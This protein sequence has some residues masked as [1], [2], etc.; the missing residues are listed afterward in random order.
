MSPIPVGSQFAE[1]A[2]R[3]LPLAQVSSEFAACAKPDSSPRVSHPTENSEILE[4]RVDLI[5][6]IEV[7]GSI[8]ISKEVLVKVVAV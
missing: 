7:H 8:L 2:F 3:V 1:G 6:R 5:Q 4:H